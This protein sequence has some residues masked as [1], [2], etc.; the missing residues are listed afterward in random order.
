MMLS[1]DLREKGRSRVEKQPKEPEVV[2]TEEQPATVEQAE[3]EF[4]T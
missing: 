4:L 2:L 1:V 3:D